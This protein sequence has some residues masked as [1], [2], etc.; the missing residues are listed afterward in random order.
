MGS[1]LLFLPPG[2]DS[3]FTAGALGCS[4]LLVNSFGNILVVFVSFLSPKGRAGGSRGR[5]EA[6]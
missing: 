2:G 6:L 4:A 5:L 1:T 3:A